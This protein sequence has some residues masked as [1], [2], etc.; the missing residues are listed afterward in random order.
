MW[1]FTS[2]FIVVVVCMCVY[3][4]R[5][6]VFPFCMH[7]FGSHSDTSRRWSFDYTQAVRYRII[8]I[9]S[10]RFFREFES[11]PAN[12][13]PRVP[14]EV[15]DFV[16]VS[17]FENYS[18]FETRSPSIIKREERLS[19]SFVWSEPIKLAVQG[20]FTRYELQC[21]FSPRPEREQ[22]KIRS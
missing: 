16:L 5:G 9:I 22:L 18:R 3:V 12:D 19:F 11:F 17:F 21:L 6:T 10:C 2:V 7:A 8:I 15:R 14:R 1:L 20:H 4:R 13:R